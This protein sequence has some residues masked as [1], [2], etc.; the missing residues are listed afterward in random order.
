MYDTLSCLAHPHFVF[1]DGRYRIYRKKKVPIPDP[2]K[3]TS[4]NLHHPHF[5]LVVI[6]EDTAYVTDLFAV[7]IDYFA[8]A[9]VQARVGED[10]ARIPQFYKRSIAH[11]LLLVHGAFLSRNTGASRP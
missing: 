4:A 9:N 8:T 2:E 11:P 7:L 10:Q 6:D 3:A 5:P 1:G